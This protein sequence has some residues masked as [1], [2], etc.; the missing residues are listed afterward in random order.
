M[1]ELKLKLIDDFQEFVPSTPNFQVGYIEGRSTQQWIIAREDLDSMYESAAKEG[2]IT[3][4]C[5]KK[6][7]P[8]D[9]GSRKRKSSDTDDC[10]PASK[11]TKDEERDQELLQ[12]VDQLE[13]KHADKYSIPQLR[14]W[15]KYLQSKRHDSYDEPPNIPLITGNPDSRKNTKRE[16]VSDV[17]AGAATAIVKALRVPKKESPKRSSTQNGIA[18]SFSPNSHANLRRK[19]LEDLRTLHGLYEDGVLT[20]AEYKEQKQGIPGINLAFM[21]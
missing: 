1:A 6:V 18:Q 16:S 9:Q 14:L 21:S 11:V 3:L 19:H 17:L 2:E 20:D 4:W 5:D 7:V 13:S 8:Q 15:A 12:I 10:T